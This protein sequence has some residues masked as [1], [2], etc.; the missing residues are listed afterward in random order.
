MAGILYV[1]ASDTGDL[2]TATEAIKARILPT[3]EL[4]I[5]SHLG[6]GSDVVLMPATEFAAVSRKAVADSA[7][8]RGFTVDVVDDPTVAAD[9]K[10]I[11]FKEAVGATS[12][13]FAIYGS[14]GTGNQLAPG[15][16]TMADLTDPVTGA[17]SLLGL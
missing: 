7:D 2:A 16:A 8:G 3:G 13:S 12:A 11:E 5:S 1:F 6:L 4:E 14:T 10:R 17:L 15:T 9:P